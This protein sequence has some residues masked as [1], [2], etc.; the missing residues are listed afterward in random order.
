MTRLLLLILAM[1]FASFE[2]RAQAPAAWPSKPVRIIVPFGAG[3]TPDA[4][5]RVMADGFQ[6]ELPGATFVVENKPGASGNLGTE[7]VA[8]AEPDGATI[9]LSI[10]GP[11]AINTLLFSTLK[12]D[13]AKDI[14]AISQLVTQASIL[15]VHKS[16][17]AKSVADLVAALKADPQKF[18]FGSIGVGSLSHLAMEA[19]AQK[20]GVKLVHLPMQ[21]SPAAMTALMR[22]DVQV[23]CLPSIAVSPHAGNSDITL[24]A[25]S[26]PERSPFLPNL[27]TLKESGVPVEADAWLG[28]IA[29]AGL[30]PE[31]VERL[32]ALTVKV[33][34][35]PEVKA[36]LEAQQMQPIGSSPRQFRALIDAEI[37]RWAPII[38]A[39]GIK[40][41]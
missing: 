24:L 2:A 7:A 34:A 14:A 30:A 4:V 15:A 8:K 11:L 3:S 37:A 39:G 1:L 16:V 19:I 29:P 10:G 38:Q 13:P 31:I 23:A 27:P 9:G 17:G 12:Y 21:G 35:R 6:A 5:A 40:V 25:V 32:H 33:L 20:A 28:L 26:T 36:K 41:N 22:G 18:T